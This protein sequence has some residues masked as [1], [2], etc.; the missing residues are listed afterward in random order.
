M[1][2]YLHIYTVY[3]H[4][5]SHDLPLYIVIN[6]EIH[7]HSPQKNMVF[8]RHIPAPPLPQPSVQPPQGLHQRVNTGEAADHHQGQ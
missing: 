2:K 6:H 5:H 7:H 4:T 8:V 3:I 1:S